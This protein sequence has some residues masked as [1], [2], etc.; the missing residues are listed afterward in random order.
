MAQGTEFPRFRIVPGD[1]SNPGNS[2]AQEDPQTVAVLGFPGGDFQLALLAPPADGQS[3]HPFAFLKRFPH[4]LGRADGPFSGLHDFISDPQT[5]VPGQ[6]P[7]GVIKGGYGYGII[8]K[9]QTHD[10]S[11]RD[12]QLLREAGDWKK[13]KQEQSGEQRSHFF[14]ISALLFVC[15][16]NIP[17][18]TGL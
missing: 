6:A 15:F 5:G 16:L 1:G 10:F 2:L 13:Q 11:H 18:G 9:L 14:H 12:K 4:I 8:T 3:D 7:H 17:P